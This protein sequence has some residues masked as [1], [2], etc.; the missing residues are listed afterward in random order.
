VEA[1]AFAL[2]GFNHAVDPA[3]ADA[4]I[5]L[6]GRFNRRN[7]VIV[8]RF[9]SYRREYHGLRKCRLNLPTDIPNNAAWRS[10]V[11]A[12]FAIVKTAASPAL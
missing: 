9:A 6:R 5:F 4:E 11:H 2:R 12:P 8:W 3:D 10:R 7:S 1:D